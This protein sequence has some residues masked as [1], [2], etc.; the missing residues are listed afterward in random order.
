MKAIVII[1]TYN[2]IHNIKKLIPELLESYPS[3]D[4]LI[5]DDNS[6]D[7]TANAVDEISKND[8]RVKV[9]KRM[10]KMGLGT[11]TL[12]DSK[13]MPANGYDCCSDGC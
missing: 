4:I 10:G 13:Y 8:S 1:P 11:F 9:I 12:P 2:E 5:V 7:G 6:P 3:I